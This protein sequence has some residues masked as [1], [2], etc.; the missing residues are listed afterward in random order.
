MSDNRKFTKASYSVEPALESDA[1]DS[2]ADIGQAFPG[3]RTL[4]DM[5][6]LRGLPIQ[7]A[8]AS[9]NGTYTLSGMVLVDMQTGSGGVSLRIA[10]NGF[11]MN[12]EIDP[13]A[14]DAITSR[15]KDGLE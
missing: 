13:E 15:W 8:M 9:R 4:V 6:S 11:S 3:K 7:I 5:E 12:W 2:S 14:M 10:D 1:P